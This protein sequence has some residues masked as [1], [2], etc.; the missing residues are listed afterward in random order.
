[1]A[2]VDRGRVFGKATGMITTPRIV[3]CVALACG[4]CVVLGAPA[5]GQDRTSPPASAQYAPR[6]VTPAQPLR[7]EEQHTIALFERAAASVVNVDRITRVRNRWERRVYEVADGSGSGFFWDDRGHIVTNFHVVAGGARFR[8]TLADGTELDAAIVGVSPDDDLA[9]LKIDPSA[10][11]LHPLPVGTSADLRVGQSVYAIGNPFGLDQT[12]TT[13]VVSALGR[14]ITSLSGVDI[15]NCIQSDAAINPGN[16]GGPLLDSSGRLIGVNTAIRSPSGASAGIGFAVPVDTVNE[17]VS[18]I[19]A[20]G[21]RPRPVLGITLMH[22]RDARYLGVRRGVPVL[23]VAPG[24]AAER[25]GLLGAQAE[26]NTLT[27]GDVIAEI[28]GQPV[29]TSED[30]LRVLRSYRPG[31]EVELGI[32]RGEEVRTVRVRLDALLPDQ[33]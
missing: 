23:R 19:I 16:S 32:V 20:F 12:L 11:A 30:L 1:M 15:Q 28:S 14:T 25:A 18:Q 13:G 33:E 24:S 6:E 7:P 29:D 26:G 3:S 9:V 5:M 22:P 2:R 8:V 17:T 27:L 21:F 4:M 10:C 31:Q